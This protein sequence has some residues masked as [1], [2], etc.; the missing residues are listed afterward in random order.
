[1]LYLLSLLPLLATVTTTTETP[2]VNLKVEI[3]N[4]QTIQ[5]AVYVALF[6]PGKEFPSG[7][8]TDGRVVA[9]TSKSAHASFAVEPGTYAV[10]VFHDANSNGR[11][12]KSILGLP[13]EPY[14]FS[15]NVRPVLSVPRFSD[16]QFSVG[17]SGQ[18]VSIKLN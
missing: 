9:V 16:C 1:M 12:D 13:R 17:N 10:V 2:K 3:Q 18:A 15:N 14:G 6:Q 11:M 7:K 4:V 5:G 8:P